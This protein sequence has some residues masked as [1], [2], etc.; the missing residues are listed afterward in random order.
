M[1]RNQSTEFVS[2]KDIGPI[3]KEADMVK[4]TSKNV[5]V[6][7]HNKVYDYNYVSEEKPKFEDT[8]TGK[9]VYYRNDLLAIVTRLSKNKKGMFTKIINAALEE[10]LTEMGEYKKKGLERE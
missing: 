5:H 9:T 3:I 4:N 1:A 10:H 7:E 6:N 8:Y 2:M